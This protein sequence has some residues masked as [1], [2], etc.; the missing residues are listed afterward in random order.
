LDWDNLIE[1]MEALGKSE[2]REIES[3]LRVLIAH[4]LKRQYVKS[5]NDYRG[6]ENTIDEQ[7]SELEILL[8]QSP[9]LK[10]CFTEVFGG[11]YNHALHRVRKN[12]PDVVFPEQWPFSREISAILTEDLWQENR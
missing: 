12:Y 11:A 8:R 5:A 1:E 7:R 3:R 9:S 4:I 6:W 2:R 10:A